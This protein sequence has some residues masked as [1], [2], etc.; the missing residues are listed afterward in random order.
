MPIQSTQPHTQSTTTG[1]PI[2]T[3]PK[4]GVD[5]RAAKRGEGYV[6]YVTIKN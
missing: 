1:H 3:K 6:M 5:I 2:G 4:L